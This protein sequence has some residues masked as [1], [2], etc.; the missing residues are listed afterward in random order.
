MLVIKVL[1]LL[2][3]L[4]C[5]VNEALIWSDFSHLDV[6]LKQN[7]CVKMK[8]DLSHCNTKASKQNWTRTIEREKKF[9]E[10]SV[11]NGV[12]RGFYHVAHFPF[13]VV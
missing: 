9:S 10:T 12:L 4:K 6:Q 7:A 3:F 1:Q 11:K 13:S 8:L 5:G 2:Q